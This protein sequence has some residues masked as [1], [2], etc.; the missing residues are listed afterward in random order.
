MQ[1]TTYRQAC[2]RNVDRRAVAVERQSN[3]SCNHGLD[4]ESKFADRDRRAIALPYYRHDTERHCKEP[5]QSAAWILAG[6][7]RS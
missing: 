6:A 1:Q 4:I 7:W 2:G 3:R 5:M